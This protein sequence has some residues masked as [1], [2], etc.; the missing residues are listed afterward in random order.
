MNVIYKNTQRSVSI[1]T[2]YNYSPPFNYYS[3]VRELRSTISNGTL[4]SINDIEMK[5]CNSNLFQSPENVDIFKTL[6][7]K[8]VNAKIHVGAYWIRLDL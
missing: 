2:Q 3:Q 7:L 8:N 4:R 6:V 5:V 1:C